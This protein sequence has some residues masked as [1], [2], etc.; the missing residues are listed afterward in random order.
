ME[1][2]LSVYGYMI[3]IFRGCKSI[4]GTLKGI[5]ELF[6]KIISSF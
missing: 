6:N 5:L 4:L 2:R 1:E 3:M